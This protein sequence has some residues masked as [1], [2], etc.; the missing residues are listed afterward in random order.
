MSVGIQPKIRLQAPFSHNMVASLK[1]P[2]GRQVFTCCRPAPTANSVQLVGLCDMGGVS[3][4]PERFSFVQGVGMQVLRG[5]GPA[6]V[7]LRM[8]RHAI[9]PLQD[10]PQSTKP[11]CRRTLGQHTI[12]GLYSKGN[13]RGTTFCD[14]VQFG[15]SK[16]PEKQT[17]TPKQYLQQHLFQ[18][19]FLGTLAKPET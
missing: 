5:C 15:R 12:L 9:T 7:A 18:G 6:A 4:I 13:N 16:V 17:N 1:L 19:S 2:N 10:T 8:S 11:Y 3:R 14:H